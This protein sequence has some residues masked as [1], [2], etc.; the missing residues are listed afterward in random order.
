MSK[1]FY[2]EAEDLVLDA[3]ESL[4]LQ[5]SGLTLDKSKKSE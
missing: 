4:V 1:H 3:L 2:D 5:S